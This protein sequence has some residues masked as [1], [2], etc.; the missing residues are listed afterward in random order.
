MEGAMVVMLVVPV[1][2]MWQS[3]CSG[4]ELRQVDEVAR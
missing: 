4:P 1:A 3:P 2:V